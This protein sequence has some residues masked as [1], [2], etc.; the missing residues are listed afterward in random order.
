MTARLSIC[1][2]HIN[3]YEVGCAMCITDYK[4]RLD[5]IREL[6][7][8]DDTITVAEVLLRIESIVNNA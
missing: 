6:L 7:R 3:F 4:N 5:R 1:D 2:R 8:P